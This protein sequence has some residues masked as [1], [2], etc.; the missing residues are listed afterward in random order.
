MTGL[1]KLATKTE[2]AQIAGV[3]NSAVNNWEDRYED[4]P[5]PAVVSLSG[6]TK[7][8]DISEIVGWLRGKGKV[9]G[10][11]WMKDYL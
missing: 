6:R 11:E 1:A 7:L 8:W 2:I 9:A 4:F 3:S 10:R 5:K